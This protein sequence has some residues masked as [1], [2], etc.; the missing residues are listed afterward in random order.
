MKI[1]DTPPKVP[2][3]FPTSFDLDDG[4]C[5]VCGGEL[6]TGWECNTCGADHY[7][8]VRLL[9]EKEKGPVQ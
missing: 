8:G 3:P 2:L 7:P 6:D 9:I 4:P 1:G 5:L